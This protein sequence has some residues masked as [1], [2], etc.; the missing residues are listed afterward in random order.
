M[1]KVLYACKGVHMLFTNQRERERERDKERGRERGRKSVRNRERE[2]G[3]K[4]GR[5]EK[6]EYLFLK[7]MKGTFAH[8]SYLVKNTF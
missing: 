6:R 5:E 2:R 1:R 4:R 8:F 7:R 3:R